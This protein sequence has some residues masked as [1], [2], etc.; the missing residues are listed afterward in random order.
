[1]N[2]TKSTPLS[3]LPTQALPPSQEIINGDD[4]TTIQ[5]VLNQIAASSGGSAS[6]TPP[7][8]QQAPPQM[9]TAPVTQQQMAFMAAHN[10]QMAQQQLAGMDT[11]TLLSMIGGTANPTQ[12]VAYPTVSQQGVSG[13]PSGNMMNVLLKMLTSDFKLATII[14][15]VYIA[16]SFVPITKFLDKYLSLDRIPHAEVIIKGVIIAIV[17]TLALKSFIK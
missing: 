14:F 16:I 5:E 4:D 13:S 1:M 8:Q 2:T 12:Q 3:H 6:A 7:P 17:V 11:N 15:V 9:A 10:A